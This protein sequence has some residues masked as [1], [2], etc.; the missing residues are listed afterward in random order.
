MDLRYCSSIK[1]K[2]NPC[3]NFSIYVCVYFSVFRVLLYNREYGNFKFCC[4]D[5]SNL[6]LMQNH[7]MLSRNKYIK[8][9]VEI[10]YKFLMLYLIASSFWWGLN[11]R[12]NLLWRR[13]NHWDG[14][15]EKKVDCLMWFVLFSSNLIT[16]DFVRRV[17]CKIYFSSEDFCVIS[18]F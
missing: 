6:L 13:S 5:Q 15:W 9:W 17:S 3:F 10:A 14:R 7:A 4:V 11:E 8:H 1:L 16:L 18:L 2:G 12:F